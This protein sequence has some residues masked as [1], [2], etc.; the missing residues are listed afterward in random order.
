MSGQSPEGDD[1]VCVRQVAD[2]FELGF[3]KSLLESA[4]VPFVVLNEAVSS[5]TGLSLAYGPAQVMVARR[6]AD[7][8][9]AV[10]D[11]AQQGSGEG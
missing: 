6:D 11:P 10:L 4:D 5:S 7:D 3:I 8:A 2:P 9:R 1:L